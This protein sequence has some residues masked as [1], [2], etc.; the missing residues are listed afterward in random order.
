[1]KRMRMVMGLCLVAVLGMSAFGVVSAS[2]AAPEFGR[3]LPAPGKKGGNSQDSK[4][5]KAAVAG[6][7]AFN[8]EPG[9]GP[10]PGFEDN[11]AAGKVATLESTNKETVLCKTQHSNGEY[12]AANSK[13]TKNIVVKFTGCELKPFEVKC[14]TAG[15][16]VGELVTQ[17]LKSELGVITISGEGPI[18]NKL[19]NDLTPETGE[20]FINFECAKI[21]V[22]VTGSVIVPV[23]SNTMTNKETLK[24]TQSKGKQKPE[25]FAPPAEKDTLLTESGKN[26]FQSG[27]TITTVQLGEEKMEANSVM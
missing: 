4:C 27:Q 19:G 24:F 22:R 10:K 25:K 23:K 7:E 13:Q 6:K 11:M 2:A 18:K 16:A 14:N 12:N 26:A 17:K 3:C 20:E 15:S 8:W 9:P 21:P 5:T 1:M